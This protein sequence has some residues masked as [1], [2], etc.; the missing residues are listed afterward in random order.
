MILNNEHLHMLKCRYN[1]E[2]LSD[3]M[4]AITFFLL[5]HQRFRTR[6]W[7][8]VFVFMCIGVILQGGGRDDPQQ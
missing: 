8:Y 3:H 2:I 7:Q 5:S 4:R 6:G 1:S